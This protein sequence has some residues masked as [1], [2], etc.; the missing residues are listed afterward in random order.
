LGEPPA[1]S[2]RPSRCSLQP[3]RTLTSFACF[4]AS[5]SIALAG[6]AVAPWCD[7]PFGLRRAS[8]RKFY[9][10]KNFTAMLFNFKGGSRREFNYKPRFF[11][12]D[13]EALQQKIKQHE[14]SKRELT[15]AEE[16]QLRKARI[17]QSFSN[18]RSGERYVHGTGW[19]SPIRRTLTILALFVALFWLANAYLPSF[20][21]YLQ[22]GSTDKEQFENVEYLD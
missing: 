12:P 4:G 18:Y 1:P 22:K 11:D 8:W 16:K 15:P 14:D 6:A 21:E 2:A 9:D 13:K 17:S 10:N 7:P 19:N 20:L 3:L 5:A